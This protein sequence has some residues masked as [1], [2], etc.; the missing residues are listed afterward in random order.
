MLSDFTTYAKEIS[1][2]RNICEMLVVFIPSN[3][4][5]VPWIFACVQTQ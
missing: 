2:P 4:V 1:E 3:V 5:I